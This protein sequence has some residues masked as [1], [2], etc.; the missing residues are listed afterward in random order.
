[1]TNRSALP[2]EIQEY[3]AASEGLY[4]ATL[5]EAAAGRSLPVD[6]ESASHIAFSVAMASIRWRVPCPEWAAACVAAGWKRFE[7]FECRSLGDAFEIT[8]SKHTQAKRTERLCAY[9][10]HRVRELQAKGLPL[11]DGAKG[12]GALSQVGDEL[13]MSAKQVEKL[14]TSWRKLCVVSG[15]DPDEQPRYADASTL[16]AEAW[17]RGLSQ[18]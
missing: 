10:F 2:V 1:M 5:K 13:H 7:N 15:L 11:K 8:D 16:I 18:Q 17:T 9:T 6:A 12:V 14:M 4:Y 3:F